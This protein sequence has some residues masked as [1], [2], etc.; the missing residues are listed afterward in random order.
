M[1]ESVKV[2]R[3]KLCGGK[4]KFVYYNIPKQDNPEGWYGS[5]D[6]VEPYILFKRLECSECGATVLHLALMIDDA[7]A[8]WNEQKLLERYGEEMAHNVEEGDNDE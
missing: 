8:C 4:P 2:K 5:E 6:G 1:S 3:C 7:V